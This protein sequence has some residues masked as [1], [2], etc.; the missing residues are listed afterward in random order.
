MAEIAEPAGVHRASIKDAAD[1]RASALPQ[2]ADISAAQWRA[3]SERA[4]EPTA[5]QP[6]A[7]AAATSWEA[8]CDA[9]KRIT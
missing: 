1:A 6:T 9:L 7:A 8:K 5:A 3:L 4:T 2:F